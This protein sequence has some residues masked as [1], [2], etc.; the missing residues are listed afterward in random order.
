MGKN[1]RGEEP[2][3]LPVPL[4]LSLYPPLPTMNKACLS[5]KKC[6]AST[7]RLVAATQ[8]K[9]SR[10]SRSRFSSSRMIRADWLS[11]H[12]NSG[13]FI[14]SP[15]NVAVCTGTA[16]MLFAVRYGYA[17]GTARNA[18]LEKGLNLADSGSDMLTGDP[19]GMTFVDVLAAGSFGHVL[20]A[21]MILGLKNMGQL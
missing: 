7:S 1:E 17:P 21:G 13:G 6:V 12:V 2:D 5:S 3:T 10:V 19:M 8:N 11:E 18:K 4:P 20:A 14:G 9:V 16:I 15:T